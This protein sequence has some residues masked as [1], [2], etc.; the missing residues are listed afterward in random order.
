MGVFRSFLFAPGNHA[1]KVEKCLQL[2]ADAVILDLEDAV[3][4]AEKPAT[5]DVVVSALQVPRTGLGYVRVNAF[6]TPFCFGDLMAVVQPGLDGI[7]LPKLESAAQLIAVEWMVSQLERDR[8]LVE[9]AIDIMPIIETAKGLTEVDAICRA[10]SRVLR[11]AFGAGDYT[12]DVGMNWT[13]DERELE[14]ARHTIVVASRAADIE[15]PLDTVWIHLGELENIS[16]SAEHARDLG[17]QGKMC[18]HPEQIEPVNRAFTP[19]NETVAQARMYI[20]A[21]AQAEAQGSASIQVD[22]YF[23]DYPIVEKARRIVAIADA[24]ARN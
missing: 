3:A 11:V 20:E 15:P 10:E 18:I 2:D 7:V 6:D 5:R 19:T 23:I 12:L 9:G 1:R 4:V 24:I 14:A 16:K 17:F 8:G 21:F 22:G 13:R